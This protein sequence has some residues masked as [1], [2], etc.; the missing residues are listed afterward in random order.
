VIRFGLEKEARAALSRTGFEEITCDRKVAFWNPERGSDALD[1]IHE[2]SVRASVLL[3]RQTADAKEWVER[4][5]VDQVEAQRVDNV[6]ELKFP[7]LLVGADT[8][9]NSER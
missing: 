7:Y 4:A 8:P 5:I 9:I 6:I 1:L 3:D 2:S